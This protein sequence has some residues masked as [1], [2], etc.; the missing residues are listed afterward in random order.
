[1]HSRGVY[2]HGWARE[3]AAELREIESFERTSDI[4]QDRTL[5][6]VAER[7]AHERELGR[8]A[9]RDDGREIS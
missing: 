6:R 9:D 5:A 7:D 2:R 8:E 3:Y 1:M 4:A